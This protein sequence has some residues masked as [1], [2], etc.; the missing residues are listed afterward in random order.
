MPMGRRRVPTGATAAVLNVT[1]I[2]ARPGF[3]QVFPTVRA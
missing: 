1:A 3:V 2:G